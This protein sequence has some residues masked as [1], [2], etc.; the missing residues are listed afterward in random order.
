MSIKLDL[1]SSDLKR[2]GFL[3]VDMTKGADLICDLTKGI[4]YA[5]SSVDMIKSDHFFE[6]LDIDQLIYV[7]SE[8]Y[9]VLKRG[10]KLDFTVPHIDPYMK[11]Y[12]KN[13]INF[14]KRKISDVPYK[15]KEIFDTP[16]D[17]I[18]WLIYRNGEHKTFFDRKSIVSKLKY[19][20]FS[21]I[22]IRKFDSKK[23]INKR[24]SSIYIEAIK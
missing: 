3:S 7:L 17:I 13:D 19:V 1:G 4:P 21:K 22:S 20:G 18:T 23:D 12:L 15:Y 11:A 5:D 9:R 2:K 6:H 10:H 16:F 24:F 14:L 8:C